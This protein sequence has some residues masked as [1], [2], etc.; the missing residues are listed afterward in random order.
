MNLSSPLIRFSPWI[1][2]SITAAATTPFTNEA[3]ER[4]VNYRSEFLE[5]AIVGVAGSSQGACFADL[6]NDGDADLILVGDFF[7]VVGVFEN[8]GRG[9]F[10]RHT[11]TGMPSLQKASGISAGD[12]DADGDLDIFLTQMDYPTG[13]TSGNRLLRNEGGFFFQDVSGEAGIVPGGSSTGSSWG[14]FDGDGWL[15]LYVSAYSWRG[16]P[17]DNQLYHNQGDGTLVEVGASVGVSN[18]DGLTFQSSFIDFDVDGDVDLYIVNDRGGI[19]NPRFP[20]NALFENRAGQFVDISE[21]SGMNV[22]MFSMG[23]AVGDL[24]ADG[25]FDF[26]VSNIRENKLFINVGNNEFIDRAF[27]YGVEGGSVG[28]GVQFFDMDNDGWLELYVC[29]TPLGRDG[30]P[31][32]QLFKCDGGDSCVDIAPTMGLE[33]DVSSYAVASADID[34]DGDLD[35]V[36]VSPYAP[37]QLYIN[38][39]ENDPSQRWLR[40]R[41]QNEGRN[42]FAIGATVFV[43]AGGVTRQRTLVAGD[44]Y[45]SQNE[46]ILHFGLGSA[47]RA[48]EVRVVW[49]GGSETVAS[50]IALNQTIDIDSLGNVSS[51]SNDTNGNVG[52]APDVLMPPTP[53]GSSLCGPGLIG[54]LSAALPCLLMRRRK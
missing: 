7:G 18:P 40:V 3:V 23:I 6:D 12:Y 10:T 31:P 43:T 47:T 8:D 4:G 46:L 19:G 38:H 49:P 48:D 53:R 17:I 22:D 29:N 34:G 2:S 30:T 36:V 32:P 15:D 28:W 25:L 45:K 21:S 13:T 41:L 24:N 26:Y 9:H 33:L 14:D 5:P 51:P 44:G 39:A 42:R 52:D 50:N 54:P 1:L 11:N 16:S 20:G 37:V 35:L 27:Q